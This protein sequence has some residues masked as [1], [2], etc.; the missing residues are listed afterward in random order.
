MVFVFLAE[1][2]IRVIVIVVIRVLWRMALRRFVRIIVVL[3]RV[4]MVRLMCVMV[5]LAGSVV[6][7]VRFVLLLLSVVL[8]ISVAAKD[9]YL[10]IPEHM[11]G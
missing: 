2:L 7:L 5:V 11:T 10:P 4:I 9:A 3:L 1:L 6:M 8:L